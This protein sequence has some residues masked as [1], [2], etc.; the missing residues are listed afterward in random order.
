MRGAVF[1]RGAAALE[2]APSRRGTNRGG[3]DATLVCRPTAPDNEHEK[4]RFRVLTL[5]E[6]LISGK[7]LMAKVSRAGF[8]WPWGREYRD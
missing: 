1:G 3:V 5:D 7:K 6:A 4:L 8:S 2:N